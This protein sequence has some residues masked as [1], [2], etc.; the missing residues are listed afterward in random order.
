[1]ALFLVQ[2]GKSL[3]KDMDPDPGLTTEGWEE[4]IH[5]AEVAANYK[6]QVAEIRHS[7][8]KRAQE[9]ADIFAEKLRLKNAVSEMSG[10]K[11]MDDVALFSKNIENNRN[12]MFVGHLPFMEKLTAYLTTGNAELTVFRFQNSG[13]VCLE[14]FEGPAG[15]AIKW[16]L[17]P[18]IV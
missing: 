6:I 15:W 12:M 5:I 14:Q 8:K 3:P 18:N 4:T 16:A 7:G 1:M 11:P 17:M 10:L 13:I 2:H 9:T